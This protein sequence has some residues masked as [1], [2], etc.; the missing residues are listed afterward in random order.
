MIVVMNGEILC[1]EENLALLFSVI[2]SIKLCS[3]YK[4]YLPIFW[5]LNNVRKSIVHCT[6]FLYLGSYSRQRRRKITHLAFKIRVTW[7]FPLPLVI[8]LVVLFFQLLAFSFFLSPK[9][10]KEGER[11]RER[12]HFNSL[13]MWMSLALS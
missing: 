5:A 6:G 8:R 13:N 9:N 3:F 12:V 7:C 11:E 1:E 4:F 10:F 2:Y